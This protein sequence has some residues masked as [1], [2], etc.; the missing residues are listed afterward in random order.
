MRDPL[1]DASIVKWS[2]VVVPITTKALMENSAIMGLEGKGEAAEIFKA[3]ASAVS[4]FGV[5]ASPEPGLSGAERALATIE[6]ARSRTKSQELTVNELKRKTSE[7]SGSSE[8]TVQTR[9]RQGEDADLEELRAKLAAETQE[10]NRLRGAQSAWETV[11]ILIY[12]ALSLVIGETK[13]HDSNI[14]RRAQRDHDAAQE[15][16]GV[17]VQTGTGLMK[18]IEKQMSAHF[19]TL[20]REVEIFLQSNNV[21][22]TELFLAPRTLAERL[23]DMLRAREALGGAF[24]T[25]LAEPFAAQM[26]NTYSEMMIADGGNVYITGYR[27]LL[28]KA[29]VTG[30]TMNLKEFADEIKALCDINP[31]FYDRKPTSAIRAFLGLESQAYQVATRNG[32]GPNASRSRPPAPRPGNGES[33][34][35]P[36]ERVGC[37]RCHSMKHYARNCPEKDAA[38]ERLAARN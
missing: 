33:I 10:L 23:K 21:Y 24:V 18:E 7:A 2:T 9:S 5:R 16:G 8:S 37:R 14:A 4:T 6:E 15:G 1:H 28:E 20:I 26:M 12:S 25:P 30:S 36:G 27:T 22:W 34:Y 17:S 32:S 38:K 3:A 35:P 19:V 11:D 29:M 13:L 31:S